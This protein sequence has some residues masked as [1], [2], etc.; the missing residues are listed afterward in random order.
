MQEA[1]R[2][3]LPQKVLFVGEGGRE[4][5]L[6]WKVSMDN[7]DVDLRF[8]PGNGGTATL[9]SNIN[10]D[11]TDIDKLVNYSIDSDIDLVVVGPEDPLALGLVNALEE[12]DEDILAFGPTQRAAELESDKG[13]AID[14]MQ[15]HGIPHPATEKFEDPE[16]A[17]RFFDVNSPSDY[18]IKAIGLARG[19]GVFLPDSVEKARVII[20]NLMRRK[21][22]GVAGEKIL[23]QRKL[24]GTEVSVIALVSNEIQLLPLARDYK[25]A[26]DGDLGPNTGGMGAYSPNNEITEEELNE[27]YYRILSPTKKGMER[28][29]SS[30][31]GVLYVGIMMT[32]DGPQVL[33]YN[34]RFGDP[35]TQV[36]SRIIKPNLLRLMTSTV[37]RNLSHADRMIQTNGKHAVG[38]VLTS[39]GYP[40]EYESGI[41]IEGLDHIGRETVVFHS[42]TTR[43]KD[44]LSTSGGRVFTVTAIGK[45]LDIAK[46]SA[47][48]SV[49]GI[50][51][52][53]KQYRKD[54][55]KRAEEGS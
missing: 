2:L 20:N 32:E 38:V 54:I 26:F 11:A 50:L 18:V 43:N 16:D 53:G 37:E 7:P 33:E 27:I 45:T 34:V 35:E 17:I 29:G 1:P 46:R 8:A 41:E 12:A 15:K 25:R 5:A 19:K 55:G 49:E 31:K 24:T 52:D 22:L 6:G 9:G 47:Y 28:D 30:F 3:V 44:N 21:V 36:Q 40:G 48:E 10:I 39:Q 13:A 23:A 51:F 42:G 4:H 14:F